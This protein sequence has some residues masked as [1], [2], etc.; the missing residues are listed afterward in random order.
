MAKSLKLEMIAEGV[1]TGAQA[2]FLQSRG[3]QFAQGYFFAKP[4]PLKEFAA[5][6]QK[7]EKLAASA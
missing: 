7:S 5:F 4:M 2:T 1:E 3:V 6:V